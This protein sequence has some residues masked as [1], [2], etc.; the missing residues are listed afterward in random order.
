M[1]VGK[2]LSAVEKRAGGDDPDKH[3]NV[4]KRSQSM[5]ARVA[6]G[7]AVRSR[8]EP[9]RRAP[10]TEE[11]LTTL[12]GRLTLQNTRQLREQTSALQPTVLRLDHPVCCAMDEKGKNYFQ[13]RR[14]GKTITMAGSPHLH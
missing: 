6:E 10:A 5:G 14:D 13:E 7:R 11:Q 9:Q 1:D 12:I 2:Y 8:R 4:S 3:M